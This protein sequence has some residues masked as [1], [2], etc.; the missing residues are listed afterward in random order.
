VRVGLSAG[1]PLAAEVTPA[2]A[3]QMG[4]ER[5]SGVVASWK[6]TATRLVPEE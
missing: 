2:G 1:Q 4:L 6:A 5:G 3:A